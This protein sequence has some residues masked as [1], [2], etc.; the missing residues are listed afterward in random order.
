MPALFGSDRKYRMLWPIVL[1]FQIAFWTLTAVVVVI[2]VL[3][4]LLKWRRG[5]TFLV[6]SVLAMAALIPACTGIMAVVDQMRFGSFEYATVDDVNDF[7]AERYLPTAALNIQMHKQAN[8]YFARY[9]ISDVAFHA[10]LDQLWHE[11]GEHSA[12]A[13]GKTYGEGSPAS[14]EEQER[15]FLQFGWKPLENAMIYYGPTEADG[16]GAT[17]YFDGHAGVAMQRTGYW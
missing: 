13:R 6:S 16:G 11:Y 9:A 8:G 3:A 2:S 5:Q 4:P 12:V 10:Y 15:D 14:K 1:P 17:Y 7:R